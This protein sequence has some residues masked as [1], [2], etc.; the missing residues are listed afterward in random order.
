[1]PLVACGTGTDNDTSAK[2]TV[3]AALAAGFTSIDTARDYNCQKG[4]G[5]ALHKFGPDKRG[6]IFLTTK[7]PGCGV[8]TQGLG[9]PCFANSLKVSEQPLVDLQ[10]PYV[11]L[12]LLHFP[13]IG[14]NMSS[15]AVHC[16]TEATCT[17]MQQQ[18]AALEQLYAANKTRAI[19]VSNH[20]Q[21][22]IECILKNATIKPMVNQVQYHVGIGGDPGGL[23]AYCHSQGIVP[24]A[25][26]PLLHGSVLKNFSLGEQLAAKY[27]FNSSAQ[28]ALAWIAQR[29][30]SMPL[31]THSTNPAYLSE[32]LNLFGPRHIISDTDRAALNA[33]TSPKCKGDAPGACC[34]CEAA[35]DDEL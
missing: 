26:S 9:P 17:K 31:V 20:C 6:D 32:D 24:E 30:G 8:P 23:I 12:L 22:C 34:Q 10:T 19:G 11:D 21:T 25:Y 18:W 29:K 14:P 28:V 35:S 7:I 5:V 33:I 3:A 1:M 16:D 13:P 15:R 27:G 2:S 4:V